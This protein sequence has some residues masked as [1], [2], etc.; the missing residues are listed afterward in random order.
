MKHYTSLLP[1]AG[2]WINIEQVIRPSRG[3][4]ESPVQPWIILNQ[5][6]PYDP[7]PWFERISQRSWFR[8]FEIFSAIFS[9]PNK[10]KQREFLQ[11]CWVSIICR[12]HPSVK[13]PICSTS[14]P[15]LRRRTCWISTQAPGAQ[16][17]WRHF[18]SFWWRISHD[19]PMKSYVS[20]ILY[21]QCINI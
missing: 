11:T 6:P 4:K 8:L 21:D 14:I 1:S 9:Y 12:S 17:K 13:Q 18:D 2:R 3:E 19:S 15:G 20:P 5:R 10:K 7:R 16:P